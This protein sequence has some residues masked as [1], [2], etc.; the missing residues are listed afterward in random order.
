[1]GNNDPYGSGVERAEEPVPNRLSKSECGTGDED[2]EG[3][4][5]VGIGLARLSSRVLS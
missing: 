4:K 3:G 2:D 1:M 5:D